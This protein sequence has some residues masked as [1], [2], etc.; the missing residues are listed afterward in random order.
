[1]TVGQGWSAEQPLA[2]C[3]LP[4]RIHPSRSDEQPLAPAPAPAP[5]PRSAQL[6]RP[7]PSAAATGGAGC[8]IHGTEFA[9]AGFRNQGY[10]CTQYVYTDR[11]IFCD[12]IHQSTQCHSH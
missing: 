11:D 10:E 9:K 4:T 3:L 1:M 7:G 8:P 2:N 12:Q 5:A 6:Q